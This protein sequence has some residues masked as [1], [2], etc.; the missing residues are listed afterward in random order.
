M[1][2][3]Y[4]SGVKPG[5]GPG[6]GL[7]IFWIFWILA[8]AL[9]ALCPPGLGLSV[10]RDYLGGYKD[11]AALDVAAAPSVRKAY[12]NILKDK[13]FLLTEKCLHS[14]SSNPN[15][16]K[17]KV[18]DSKGFVQW[19]NSRKI[20]L[21]YVAIPLSSLSEYTTINARSLTKV[22]E[23]VF[24]QDSLNSAPS[25]ESLSAFL[26]QCASAVNINCNFWWNITHDD[27]MIFA[28]IAN[29]RCKEWIFHSNQPLKA[30]TV[31][32][33]TKTFSKSLEKLSLTAQ[34]INSDLLSTISYACNHLKVISLQTNNSITSID[35]KT[36]FETCSQL[37]SICLQDEVEIVTDDVLASLTRCHPNLRLL[38]CSL[39]PRLSEDAFSTALAACSTLQSLQCPS[40][41]YRIIDG[42]GSAVRFSPDHYS[43][44]SSQLSSFL[45]HC[46]RPVR[47]FVSSTP[48]DDS[49]LSA[50]GDGL[51]KGIEL[52]D[53][54]LSDKASDRGIEDLFRVCAQLRCLR[55][56]RC[57]ILSSKIVYSA[58]EHCPIVQTLSLEQFSA[59]TDEVCVNLVSSLSRTLRSLSLQNCEQLGNGSLQAI[60]T[61]CEGLRELDMRGCAVDAIGVSQVWLNDELRNLCSLRV[62]DELTVYLQKILQGVRRES[63]AARW[64]HILF[65]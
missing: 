11:F 7:W 64:K 10:L 61:Y 46:L 59:C 17:C 51:V 32:L 60:A 43:K 6:P 63:P 48:L 26:R 45:Q 27:F 56:R 12:F 5:F 25:R 13:S 19:V 2:V 44:M 41:G 33:I 20:Y 49:A 50:L 24:V 9:F 18:V 21:K 1:A 29:L 57:A 38:D 62:D 34:E 14:N 15:S 52:L 35:L 55:I 42:K 36:F 8:M 28:S 47:E 22:E 30:H 23:V 4:G 37:Q 58:I 53:L 54:C 16:A 39:C 3:G 31:L 40:C 65:A